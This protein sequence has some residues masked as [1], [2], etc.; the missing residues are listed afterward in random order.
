MKSCFLVSFH[1]VQLDATLSYKDHKGTG[2]GRCVLPFS[3]LALT[4]P[5]GMCLLIWRE[6]ILLALDCPSL[7]VIST[8]RDNTALNNRVYD[9]TFPV[10]GI[11]PKEIKAGYWDICTCMIMEA[12]VT[13]GKRLEAAQVSI[14]EWMDKPNGVCPYSGT[15]FS[16]KTGGLSDTCYDIDEPGRHHAK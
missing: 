14:S 16:M 12:F 1:A 5:L 10:G 15:V 4:L 8:P 6:H 11:Y 2:R 3:W 7:G 9:P 13:I